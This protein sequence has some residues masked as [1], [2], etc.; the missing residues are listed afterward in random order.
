MKLT[1]KQLKSI[2]KE[3]IERVHGQDSSDMNYMDI[4][5]L[6]DLI[7]DAIGGNYSDDEE[8]FSNLVQMAKSSNDPAISSLTDEQLRMFY[9]QYQDDYSEESDYPNQ[10]D[11]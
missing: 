3:E 10:D 1:L 5:G 11:E 9:E 2:I 4:N 8:C 7:F 6:D